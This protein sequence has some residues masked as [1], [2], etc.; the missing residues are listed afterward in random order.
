M[1]TDLILQDFYFD[2]FRGS[3]PFPDSQH[4]SWTMANEPHGGVLKDLVLRDFPI[5][6]ELLAEASVLPSITLTEVWSWTELE[7]V[8]SYLLGSRTDWLPA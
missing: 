3:S 6:R 7:L 5:H 2:L 8:L 4:A 1:V